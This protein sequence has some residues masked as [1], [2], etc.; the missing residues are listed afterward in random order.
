MANTPYK[1]PKK[2]TS[3]TNTKFG[4][5]Q[6]EDTD[7]SEWI[8]ALFKAKHG[9]SLSDSMTKTFQGANIFSNT[10]MLKPNTNSPGY[11]FTTRPDLN[12]STSNIM[13]E[14]K[15]APLLTDKEDSLM[16]AI[17]MILSP[18][19]AANGGITGKNAFLYPGYAEGIPR[20]L[21][22]ITSR[23]INPKY[24]FIAISDNTVKSL[25]GWPSNQLGIRSTN[26]GILK[27][28]HIMA[29]APATYNGEYSLSLSA[30]SMK[31]NPV[32]YLYYYWIL[33]I[34]FIYYQTYGLMPWPEYLANGR[35]DYTCRIYRLIMDESKTYVTEMAATGY[36]IP[37]SID[38][39]PVF[40]YQSP[41]E[42]PRPYMDRTV[43]I[44]FACSGAIYMDEIL[45]QQ[46]NNTVKLF[47]Y[48]MSQKE[49]VYKK[50][51]KQYLGIFNNECYPWINPVTRELEWWIEKEKYAKGRKFFELSDISRFQGANIYPVGDKVNGR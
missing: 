4:V 15:M 18:R 48:A 8:D 43:D 44:E 28:V 6:F 33:Y 25:T 32:L 1:P 17:R 29:D 20:D 7:F 36:A 3:K 10:P 50:V 21:G 38:I 46:F 16:R 49:K 30:Y 31:G 2:T 39:G 47:N 24:P 13:T 11:I 40:D 42:N 37:R 23:L 35:L 19:L 14:R 51:E 34:G 9:F 22:K 26:P 5:E 41:S 45:I 27:E 12:L